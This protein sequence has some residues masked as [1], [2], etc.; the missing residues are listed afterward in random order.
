LVTNGREIVATGV[1]SGNMISLDFYNNFDGRT[2]NDLGFVFIEA[3]SVDTSPHNPCGPF[4]RAC[5]ADNNEGRH[6][7]VGTAVPHLLGAAI[8]EPSSLSI[9]CLTGIVM[10]GVL[11]RT[12]LANRRRIS[13][14]SSGPAS[15][16]A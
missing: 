7:V 8:P 11:V 10:G 1:S 12:R 15:L 16:A 2:A 14:R 5:V 4:P 6:D 3:P 9:F 13:Q